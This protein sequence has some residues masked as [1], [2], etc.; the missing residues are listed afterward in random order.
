MSLFDK[1]FDF[2]RDGETSTSEKIAGLAALGMLYKAASNTSAASD[3]DFD[4]DTFDDDEFDDDLESELENT[5]ALEDKRTILYELEDDLIDLELEEPDDM[6]SKAYDRW[7][8]K[9]KELED[10]IS[11][12]EDEILELEG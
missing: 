1:L 3:D 10:R 7:E 9:K 4:D 6:F 12:L 5:I 8:E 11:D 2:N